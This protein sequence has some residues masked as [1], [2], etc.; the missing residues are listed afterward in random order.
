MTESETRPC[1][2][3]PVD[4]GREFLQWREG[5]VG[6]Y[7]DFPTL[8]RYDSSGPTV[9]SRLQDD[10]FRG[11]VSPTGSDRTVRTFLGRSWGTDDLDGAGTK[12]GRPVDQKSTEKSS[13]PR[14]RVKSTE[15][16]SDHPQSLNKDETADRE[17]YRR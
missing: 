7:T 2:D 3:L 15:S 10:P 5:V 14:S 13:D 16:L 8:C 1:I 4:V 12:R 17:L 11:K 9:G 6:G